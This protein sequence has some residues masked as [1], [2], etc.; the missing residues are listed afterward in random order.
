MSSWWFQAAGQK[1]AGRVADGATSGEHMELAAIMGLAIP[2]APF[3]LGGLW[4]WI[5]HREK[6]AE[7][8]ARLLHT[9]HAL[10]A[11]SS[12][13]IKNKELEERVRVLE[14]IVTSS[15]YDLAQQIDA[16]SGKREVA[17]DDRQSNDEPL[18]RSQRQEIRHGLEP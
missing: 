4:M 1:L 8:E 5:R 9:R 6:L 11:N 18:A 12:G 15:G 2:L 10:D 14:R 7:M 16:L 17:H 3:G 13:E